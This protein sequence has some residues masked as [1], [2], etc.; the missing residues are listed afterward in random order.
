M[1]DFPQPDWTAVE[2]FPFLVA[3]KSFR[4]PTMDA[5][6]AQM[7]YYRKPD[8][9][10]AA[11]AR[12]GPLSEGAPGQVHGGMILTVM[13]EALGAAAWLEGHHVVT[14]RLTTEFRRTV[15]LN[16]TLL[17]ETRLLSARHRL[18]KVEGTLTGADGTLYANAKGEFMEL[19]E[20]ARRRIFGV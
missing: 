17:V 15:P 16:A 10:M 19:N 13:D 5:N 6:M 1:A 14:A 20:E 3:R 12:F 18:V 8:G 2:P 4:G 11:V 9:A 7:R